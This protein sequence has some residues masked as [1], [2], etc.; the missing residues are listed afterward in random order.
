MVRR[1]MGAVKGQCDDLNTDLLTRT[2]AS[3]VDA[4]IDWQ[5]HVAAVCIVIIDLR[6]Q[7][8]HR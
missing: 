3:Q 1:W 6:L 4:A 8:T 2:P 7:G 5:Y